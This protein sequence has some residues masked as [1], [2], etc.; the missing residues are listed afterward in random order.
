MPLL[1]GVLAS[2]ISAHLFT[3]ATAVDA[4]QTVTLSGTQSY[5][6]FVNIPQTYTHLMLKGIS[7]NSSTAGAQDIQVVINNDVTSQYSWHRLWGNG[8]SAT[9][10]GNS[11][12][13]YALLTNA[14]GNGNYPLAVGAIRT[15]ILD[16]SSTTKWKTIMGMSGF[17]NNQAANNNNITTVLNSGMYYNNSAVQSITLTPTSSSFTANTSFTLYGIK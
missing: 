13:S 15:T 3:A 9:S 1:P 12:T 17:D 14:A 7:M 10:G 2:E 4:I 6:V 16:Y 8:S 11:N 5:I